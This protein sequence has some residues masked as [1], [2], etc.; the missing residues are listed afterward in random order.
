MSRRGWLRARCGCPRV[1]GT[2]G[3]GVSSCAGP[4]LRV[5]W[6]EGRRAQVCVAARRGAASLASVLGASVHSCCRNGMP[7]CGAPTANASR[8]SGRWKSDTQVTAGSVPGWMGGL[9]SCLPA[10]TFSPSP[11]VTETEECRLLRP[12]LHS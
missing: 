8:S 1:G 10:P 3:V 11:N 6:P 9:S 5:P 2:S 12:L 4:Q 7:D